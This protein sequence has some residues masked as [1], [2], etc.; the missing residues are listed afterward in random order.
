ML[1]QRFAFVSFLAIVPALT[2]CG[3]DNKIPAD[4]LTALEKADS[5][6]LYS[7]DP[8]REP[9]GS[10]EEAAASKADPNKFQGWKILG[11]TTVKAAG[12]RTKVVTALKKGVA[13]ND[14]M[15]AAC[16]IPRHG[17]RVQH[18]GKVFDVVI[19]FQCMSANTFVDDK[20]T[21]G[22]LVTGSPQPA[23]DAVLTAAKVP[24]PKK[25]AD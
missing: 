23:F 15:V 21:A 9:A 10:D 7:L 13:E 3:A 5:F 22:F 6:E 4:V 25:A 19:C 20:P 8:S 16:F 1:A 17:I 12:D 24:L 11:S 14:G 18:G 2:A